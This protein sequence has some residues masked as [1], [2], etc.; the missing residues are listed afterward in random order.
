MPKPLPFGVAKENN[1]NQEPN[2][3]A[4]PP[5]ANGNYEYSGFAPNIQKAMAGLAPEHNATAALFAKISK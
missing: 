1:S 4:S 3:T 2:Q 5:I